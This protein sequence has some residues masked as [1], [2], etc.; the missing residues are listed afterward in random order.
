[1]HVPNRLWF[2]TC[3]VHVAGKPAAKTH[4]SSSTTLPRRELPLLVYS[5]ATSVLREPCLDSSLLCSPASIRIEPQWRREAP[6]PVHTKPKQ[7]RTTA[8]C[9]GSHLAGWAEGKSQALAVRSTLGLR[10]GGCRYYLLTN[11]LGASL[12][13]SAECL[14]EGMWS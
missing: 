11:H 13:P 12:P 5:G 6:I 14:W 7:A 3:F 4:G 8:F 9:S 2:S 10:P 1:M